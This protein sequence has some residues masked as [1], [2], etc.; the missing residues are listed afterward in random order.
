MLSE[1]VVGTDNTLWTGKNKDANGKW[2][3]QEGIVKHGV[4]C[5]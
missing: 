5:S 1:Y 4:T 3:V 2:V